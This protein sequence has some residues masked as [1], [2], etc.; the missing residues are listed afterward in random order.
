MKEESKRSFVVDLREQQEVRERVTMYG[1]Y[2]Q[3]KRVQEENWRFGEE[4]T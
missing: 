2:R 3:G 1:K 4:E